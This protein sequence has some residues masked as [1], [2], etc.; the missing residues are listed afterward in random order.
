MEITG[1]CPKC[2]GI[3]TDMD[4]TEVVDGKLQVYAYCNECDAR[5]FDVFELVGRIVLSKE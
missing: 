3:D 4:A 2:G 5:W 1:K